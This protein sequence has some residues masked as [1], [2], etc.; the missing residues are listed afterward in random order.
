MTSPVSAN[1][2]RFRARPTTAPRSS[3][4]RTT[5]SRTTITVDITAA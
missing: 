1:Q 5:T 4:A 2:R 3:S